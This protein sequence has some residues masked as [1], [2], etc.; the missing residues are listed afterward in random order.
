M[1]LFYIIKSKVFVQRMNLAEYFAYSEASNLTQTFFFQKIRFFSHY[2][3]IQKR[4]NSMWK[5]VENSSN[6]H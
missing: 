1:Y 5:T 3:K 6:P 2:K 4:Q